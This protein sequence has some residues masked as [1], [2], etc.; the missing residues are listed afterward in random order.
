MGWKCAIDDKKNLRHK[1]SKLM[2]RMMNAA[3]VK[4]F[5]SLKLHVCL[6]KAARARRH[7]E[8]QLQAS[9]A[10]SAAD[11][12]PSRRF[13]GRRH[14]D[15]QPGDHVAGWREEAGA[16]YQNASLS[17]L[18]HVSG[19]PSSRTG[20][21]VEA[22]SSFQRKGLQRFNFDGDDISKYLQEKGE[23]NGK[24]EEEE[25]GSSSSS[26]SSSEDEGE[27][28]VVGGIVR[29]HK[30]QK[31]KELNGAKGKVKGVDADRE[32]CLRVVVDVM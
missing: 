27:Q 5:A 29:I 10:S 6:K 16:H 9:S 2:Y 4:G 26:S 13:V 18:Y 24:A 20:H 15:Y 11:G 30:L 25:Q 1:A 3:A 22:D 7:E 12:T 14:H 8:A 23:R 21:A 31:C 17:S 32:G 28:F 19:D